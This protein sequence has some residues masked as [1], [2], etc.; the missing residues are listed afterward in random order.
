MA[1]EKNSERIFM[2]ETFSVSFESPQS[3]WM[4]LRLKAG[5]AQLVLGV[6][7]AP[8]DP[9]RELIVGLR[10]LLD[11]GR[12]FAVRWNC[13]P[14]EYDFELAAA[15]GDDVE[16]TATRYPN[17]RRR[18]SER[19]T[20]FAHRAP[21]AEI[22]LAF[23]TELRELRRRSVEDVFEANWRREFPQREMQELTRA[24]RSY[25]RRARTAATSGRTA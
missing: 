9:L 12:S 2:S 19:R 21:K 20:A 5:A 13:E 14:E 23:W 25:K 6:S 17:H 10:G 8:G 7:H 15:C 11:E 3:G 4:A 24:V 22:C 16:F 18:A 1:L